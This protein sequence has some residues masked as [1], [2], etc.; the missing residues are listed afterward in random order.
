MVVVIFLLGIGWLVVVAQ[1]A[2]VAV[3]LL[4]VARVSQ[5]LIEDRLPPLDKIQAAVFITG[6]ENRRVKECC[7]QLGAFLQ[8]VPL[9]AVDF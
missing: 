3:A 7:Q 9:M 6:V 5:R 8:L 4:K 2:V 1:S